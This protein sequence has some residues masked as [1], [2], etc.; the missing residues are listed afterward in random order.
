MPSLGLLALVGLF[1]PNASSPP[2]AP[3]PTPITDPR[4]SDPQPHPPPHP[5]PHHHPNP[6]PHPSPQVI[7]GEDKGT[8]GEIEKVLTKKGLVVVKGV[9]IKVGITAMMLDVCCVGFKAKL[10]AN[11]H[12]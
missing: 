11:V 2:P 10:P 1:A 4:H 7:A 5:H 12:L 3:H 9:N 6:Q 8:V